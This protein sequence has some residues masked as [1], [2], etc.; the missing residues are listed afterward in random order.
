MLACGFLIH[1][2]I[3]H[4]SG[5]FSL[6]SFNHV[7]SSIFHT[8]ILRRKGQSSVWQVYSSGVCFSD[9]QLSFVRELSFLQIVLYS[10]FMIFP[11]R[12]WLSPIHC[13][14]ALF[15]MCPWTRAISVHTELSSHTQP[16]LFIRTGPKQKNK[17][18]QSGV[19]FPPTAEFCNS[20]LLF[21]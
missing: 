7:L 14:R 9:R 11:L 20:L 6:L 10:P 13:F 2:K 5:K 4:N 19:T 16:S 12:K 8:E 1:F 15:I 21:A 17:K 18:E 3:L